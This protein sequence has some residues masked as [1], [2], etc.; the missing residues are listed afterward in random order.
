MSLVPYIIQV[1][2]K[3]TNKTLPLSTLRIELSDFTVWNMKIADHL[4]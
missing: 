2:I 3:L 4:K 1:M